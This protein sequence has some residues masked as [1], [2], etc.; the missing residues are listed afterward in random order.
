MIAQK[1]K[2]TFL[3][4]HFAMVDWPSIQPFFNNLLQRNIDSLD[5]LKRFLANWSEL[6]GAL[7]EE[8]G[9]RYIHVSRDT[10][11]PVVKE[12]YEY[13]LKTI[14]PHLTILTNQLE[15]KVL[16]AKDCAVLRQESAFDIF[17]KK[18]ACN[19]RCHRDE[20]IPIQTEIKLNQ[21]K[22]AIISGAMSVEVEGRELTLQQATAY[23]ESTDRNFRK[24][25]YDKIQQRRLQDKE[26]L[27]ALYTT[28]VQQR[29][30][31]A[32]NAGFENFR[33]YSFVSMHRF[34]Y[35]PQDC[36]SFHEAV[37][38]EIVPLLNEWAIERKQQLGVDRLQPFDHMV[39]AMGREPLRPFVD[40]A[41]LIKKTI[42]VFEMLDPFLADCLRT[43]DQMGHLDL[44]SRKG[45][46]PGG[47]NYPL[48]ETGVP[49]IFMNAAFTVRDMLTMFHEGGHAVHSF[50]VHDLP[51]NAFKHYP[52]EVA[53]LASM[54]MEL[55]TMPHWDIFF[56]D[57][58]ELRRAKKDHL[59]HVVSSLAWMAAIDAFQHWV[60]THPDHTWIERRENWN[61]IFSSF[62]DNITDWSG[63]EEIKDY[64]WQ[65]Q[66]HLFEVPFYYI[67][68]AIAQ[69]GAIGVWRNAQISA[70]QALRDYLRALKLG[71]TASI[72][73]VYQ[74][75][76]V[77]FNFSRAYIHALIQCVRKAWV[78][79]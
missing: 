79:L 77:E 33:D 21:Q 76:G 3:P 13:Y 56:P 43:M 35:T 4:L 18:I 29:H 53:E 17:F 39:D 67:E 69:L 31:I 41:E 24:E 20:N 75:A 55:L 27:D 28:L 22:F 40:E 25:V 73:K 57:Q 71:Y 68:Y 26:T 47:Y 7:A 44:A 10:M 12:R 6:E 65:K 66:L 2:R 60:Y 30:Q 42:Q 5:A 23:L 32:L 1:Y 14:V 74:V 34:D 52:M 49:F 59:I 64:L 58:E 48:L 46:A 9:W 72:P 54:S 45:K 38:E 16:Q 51:L 63:Y 11:D 61:R 37:R 70:E 36:F 50:L 62:S 15:E 78:L 8:F 19:L